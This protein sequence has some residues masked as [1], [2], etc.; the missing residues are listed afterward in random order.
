MTVHAAKG[1]EFPVVM[2]TGMEEQVFPIQGNRSLGRPRRA[3]GRE[4]R[5]AYVAF[6]RAEE[7]LDPQFCG[8]PTDLRSTAGGHPLPVSQ[9]AATRGRELDRQPAQAR[10][11]SPAQTATG[12]YELRDSGDSYV[13]YSEG[14]DVDRSVRPPSGHAGTTPEIRSRRSP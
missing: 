8:G 4:R 7:R 11:T 13:D 5:L 1:L 10:R 14:N 6:T 12:A 9:R 2:V 3:R